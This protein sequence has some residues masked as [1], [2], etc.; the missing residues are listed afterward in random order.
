MTSPRLYQDTENKKCPQRVML[1]R[2]IVPPLGSK[3]DILLY[4]HI[5]VVRD[6]QGDKSFL[7]HR[8]ALT[9]RKNTRNMNRA[10]EMHISI[11]HLQFS[12][13]RTRPNEVALTPVVDGRGNLVIHMEEVSGI[14]FLSFRLS[15]QT[16]GW[17]QAMPFFISNRSQQ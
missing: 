4:R 6:I 17:N 10:I 12:G 3:L 1:S 8:S 9:S 11:H 14:R 16:H 7:G 2:A 13:N 5:S 15:N